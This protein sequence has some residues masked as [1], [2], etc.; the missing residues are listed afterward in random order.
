MESLG[1]LFSWLTT[2]PTWLSPVADWLSLAA[3]LLTLGI[4]F[5]TQSLRAQYAR[6]IRTPALRQSL[7]RVASSLPTGIS[8]WP[9]DKNPV[10]EQLAK[11][12]M[13]LQSVGRKLPT[14]DGA[15]FKQLAKRFHRKRTGWL[16]FEAMPPQEY[17][18]DELW[19]LFH[20]LQ[21]VIAALEE[22]EKDEAFR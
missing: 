1:H 19:D 13:Y 20:D 11:G 5:T 14:R 7:E 15:Q 3:F 22:L 18:Q 16:W 10:L 9:T 4:L 12:R 17:K 8:E 6:R 2:P 21:A